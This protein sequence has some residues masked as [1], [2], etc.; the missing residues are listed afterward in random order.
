MQDSI[1][2]ITVLLQG[3]PAAGKSQLLNW[4]SRGV[5]KPSY[6]E[7]IEDEFTISEQVGGQPVSVKLLDTGGHSEFAEMLP[8]W[9]LRTNAQMI[10]INLED[11]QSLEY[12]KKNAT[13]FANNS[14]LWGAVVVGN[15][16]SGEANRR[17][18]TA[19]GRAFATSLPWAKFLY[20]ETNTR[21]GEV[22]AAFSALM[23]SIGSNLLPF[24]AE[25]VEITEERK[26]HSFPSTESLFSSSDLTTTD[27]VA[28]WART[29][30]I[31]K[32]AYDVIA[33]LT[34]EELEAIFVSDLPL[35]KTELS[36]YGLTKALDRNKVIASWGKRK[37]QAK[38]SETMR[39]SL[40][41]A[42]LAAQ[43]RKFAARIEALEMQ[44][45]NAAL[46]ER[47]QQVLANQFCDVELTNKGSP[48]SADTEHSTPVGQ[49]QVRVKA[50]GTGLFGSRFDSPQ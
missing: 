20:A 27:A 38:S 28:G 30:Q 41:E 21:T 31:S 22:E 17:I 49:K 23:E 44:L 5:A 8:E 3:A 43:E 4:R 48:F 25:P 2:S 40:L 32:E 42:K 47:I 35:V 9:V 6:N 1:D 34:W 46:T 16:P 50:R 13:L 12:V 45:S 24:G 29:L 11:P 18:S 26:S 14:Q 33:E 15:L 10:V 19:E 36:E 39:V 37:A 7:T